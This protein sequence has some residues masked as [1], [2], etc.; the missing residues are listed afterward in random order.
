RIE[1]G[2]GRAPGA[3]QF[4]AHALR[5]DRM[6]NADDFPADVE[7]LQMLLGPRQPNQRVIAMPGMGSNVPIWLLGS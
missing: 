5:R 3:D 7:E 4:T 6:G 1:L 2:L